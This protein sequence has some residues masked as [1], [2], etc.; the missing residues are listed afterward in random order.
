M[1]DLSSPTGDGTRTPCIGR[2]SLNHWTAREVPEKSWFSDPQS[3]AALR[4]S[5]RDPPNGSFPGSLPLPPTPAPGLS[6]PCSFQEF[7]C[8]SSCPTG[9][10]RSCPTAQFC[11]LL[12]TIPALPHCCLDSRIRKG[13]TVSPQFLKIKPLNFSTLPSSTLT[14]SHSVPAT[15]A[16]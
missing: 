13:S 1:W 16:F 3:R 11:P 14:H 10:P 8:C 12:F 4:L 2:R 6:Q 7:P 15:L 5:N 9:T